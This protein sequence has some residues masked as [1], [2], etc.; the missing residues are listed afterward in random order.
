M[1]EDQE[2]ESQVKLSESFKGRPINIMTLVKRLKLKGCIKNIYTYAG[3][4]SIT[5]VRH[6]HIPQIQEKSDA[7]GLPESRLPT[8][9]QEDSAIVLGTA[10]FLGINYYTGR[11][12]YDQNE[13]NQP[14]YFTDDDVAQ[15]ADSNW[16]T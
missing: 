15:Y 2:E 1:V 11:I 3:Q 5:D 4:A 14:N 10:D 16:Y 6:L 9:S 7:A 13:G 12:A 8:F